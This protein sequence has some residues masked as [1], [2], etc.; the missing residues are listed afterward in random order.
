MALTEQDPS[1][2][3]PEFDLLAYDPARWAP[4]DVMRIRSH[5]LR[6]NVESGVARARVACAGGLATDRD[7]Q[8]P[9]TGVDAPKV[10]EGLD[11]CAVPDG[12]LDVYRLAKA[13]VRL[14]RA[15]DEL[16]LRAADPEERARLET[17]ANAM[18]PPSLPMGGSN[19]TP[20]NTWYLPG[21]FLVRGG[22]PG[23]WS[24]T[25]ATG[26]RRA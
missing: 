8:P 7:R 12:V 11:P 14:E 6:R 16:A 15:G 1:L 17:L 23:A 9:G 18:A 22:R 25:S 26:M 3:P 13:P 5:G 19:Y 24:S 21:D 2:R 4:E 20:N 10:P